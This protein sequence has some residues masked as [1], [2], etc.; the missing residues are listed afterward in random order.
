MSFDSFES[1]V[2][3]YIH[4]MAVVDVYFPVDKHGVPD[5]SCR[6]C[7]YHRQ[8]SRTCSLNGQIVAYPEHYVGQHCPLQ[9][10]D[11]SKTNNLKSED[12]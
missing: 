9:Y 6:Q 5:I 7:P 3:K 12:T 10:E 11:D 2:T 8:Q 1:G 4:G